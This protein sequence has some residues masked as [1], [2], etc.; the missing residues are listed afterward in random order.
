MPSISSRVLAPALASLCLLLSACAQLKEVNREPTLSPVGAGLSPSQTAHID[1]PVTPV[2]YHSGNSTWQDSGADLFRDARALKVGDVVTVKIEINDK[3]SLDN[4]LKRSRDASVGL[5]SS[6]DFNFGFGAS[7]PTGSGS[8]N[9]N[10]DRTTATDSK[11][12]V[13]R[14][15][16]I[17]LLVA[18]VVS[19]V[20]PNGNLVISGSQEVRVNYELRVLNVQGVIR[21]RDINTDNTISYDKIAEARISYGGRGRVMEIQQPPYG[22]QILDIVSPF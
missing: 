12:T 9:G 20:L 15:E 5:K 19:Q 8:L 11:G 6:A 1:L 13:G 3:A 4:N 10:L 7:G 21:P 22:Q 14:S 16:T 2:A 17:N 18:A